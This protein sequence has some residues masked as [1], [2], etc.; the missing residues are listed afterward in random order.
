[1][2]S[3]HHLGGRY[4][5]IKV[6]KRARSSFGESMGIIALEAEEYGEAD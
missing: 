2:V 3:S 5:Q 4:H 6:G 1:M